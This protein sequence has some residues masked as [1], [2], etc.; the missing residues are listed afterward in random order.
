MV[1]E[2]ERRRLYQ[3]QII[4]SGTRIKEVGFRTLIW[5]GK[6]ARGAGGSSRPSYLGPIIFSWR[7]LDLKI[8][9][10]KEN[11]PKS[12]SSRFGRR[13][14]HIPAHGGQLV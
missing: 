8:A 4:H 10:I 11:L 13:A 14:L 5:P 6:N 9:K 7:N 3:D 2:L 12:I 1:V